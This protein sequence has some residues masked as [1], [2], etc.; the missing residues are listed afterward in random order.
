MPGSKGWGSEI[1]SI[2]YVNLGGRR[3]RATCWSAGRR[4]VLPAHPGGVHHHRRPAHGDH[5]QCYDRYLTADLDGDGQE[6]VVLAQAEEE[7]SSTRIEYYDSRDGV[8]TLTATSPL[9]DGTTDIS[10]WS[11]G[12]LGGRPSPPCSSPPISGGCAAHRR[13]CAG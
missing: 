2:E 5:A 9:S 8:L 1:D 4:G 7:S 10:S 13:V 6:E 11:A 3:R 12:W